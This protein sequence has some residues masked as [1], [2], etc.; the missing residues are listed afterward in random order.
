MQWTIFKNL[1]KKQNIKAGW[2]PVKIHTSVQ[3]YLVT[4][5][6]RGTPRSEK[7]FCKDTG[8]FFFIISPKTFFQKLRPFR[9]M[10]APS[11][12]V[13]FGKFISA[14]KFFC[15]N[16]IYLCKAHKIGVCGDFFQSHFAI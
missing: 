9:Q 15:S 6:Q 7:G 3:I 13:L 14:R 16:Y 10:G 1:L 5:S 11:G 4:I 2:T 12:I 8:A